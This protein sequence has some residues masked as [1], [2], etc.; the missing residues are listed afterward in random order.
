MH[1]DRSLFYSV[2]APAVGLA[3]AAVVATALGLLGVQWRAVLFWAVL[4]GCAW[5]LWAWRRTLAERPD[6]LFLFLGLSCGLLMCASMPAI[7]SVSW[8]GYVHYKVANQIAQGETFVTT[9]AD[10]INYDM[11]GIYS[12]GLVPWGTSDNDWDPNWEGVLSK[13]GMEKANGVFESRGDVVHVVE[14]NSE[15]PGPTTVGRLPNAFGLFIGYVLGAPY[16]LRLFLGRVT[17]LLF[18]VLVVWCAMRRL[19]SGRRILCAVGLLPTL[20]F[21][22]CNY[23]YDP[24]CIGLILLAFASFVGELQRPDEPI[25]L[26]GALWVLVPF[27]LGV[28]VKATWIPAGLFL[29]FMPVKKFRSRT[30]RAWWYVGCAAVALGMLWTFVGP[31]LL[32]GGASLVDDRGGSTDISPAGQLAYIWSH[33]L[34]FLG[35]VLGWGV[36]YLSRIGLYDELCVDLCYLPDPLLKPLLVAGEFLLLGLT[37]AFNRSGCDNGWPSPRLRWGA[38]VGIVLGYVLSALALYLSYTNV[39]SPTILGMQV[40]YLLLFFGPFLLLV[41]NPGTRARNWLEARGGSAPARALA[42]P[43]LDGRGWYWLQAVLPW[44]LLLLGFVVRF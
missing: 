34:S 35:T 29:L 24:W 8:D 30:A 1:V 6:R 11:D 18:W 27:T 2:P 25:T 38:L 43:I 40:R 16:L 28:M 42:A 4:L 39:G 10:A 3:T 26:A 36:T 14:D 15:A 19:R 44:G 12:V 23:S 9:G 37:T 17:N 20:L 13:E 5:I 41:L 7:V 33:P 32:D 21:E 31:F 22:A